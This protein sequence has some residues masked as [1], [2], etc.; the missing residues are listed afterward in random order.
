MNKIF[1][2]HALFVYAGTIKTA[3]QPP[4]FGDDN[5]WYWYAQKLTFSSEDSESNSNA[6]NCDSVKNHKAKQCNKSFLNQ[7]AKSIPTSAMQGIPIWATRKQK[8]PQV[9]RS[10]GYC[11]CLWAIMFERKNR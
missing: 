2:L 4:G 6:N 9:D 10:P 3:E 1:L 11:C 8:P 5:G 7:G